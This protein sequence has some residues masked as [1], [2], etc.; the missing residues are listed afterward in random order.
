M[1]STQYTPK[2]TV[3]ALQV[4]VELRILRHQHQ[5]PQRLDGVLVVVV[6]VV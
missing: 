6:V 5:L 4:D 3:M 1:N 2:L